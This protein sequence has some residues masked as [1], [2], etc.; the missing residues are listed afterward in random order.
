MTRAVQH[1]PEGVRAARMT[2]C[3]EILAGKTKSLRYVDALDLHNLQLGDE[4]MAEAITRIAEA[5]GIRRLHLGWNTLGVGA[6][7]ALA[8]SPLA[9]WIEE[10][11][12]AG[13]ELGDPG[14]AALF[15]GHF[16]SLW[17]LDVPY[18]RVGDGAAGPI[19]AM[20]GMAALRDLSLRRNDLTNAGA[21]I[22]A[23]SQPLRR[24]LTRLDVDYNDEMTSKGMRL[25]REAFGK[26]LVE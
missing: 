26:A 21:A 10:L 1:E 3:R 8:A 6:M 22:L 20:T 23:A 13:N 25:L 17:K 19:A 5:P 12:L 24:Q 15:A 18:C 14:I 7:R 4:R 16:P 2:H 9:T 11:D